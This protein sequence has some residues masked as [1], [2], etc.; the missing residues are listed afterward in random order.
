MLG[1]DLSSL[2]AYSSYQNLVISLYN[3]MAMILVSNHPHTYIYINK[4][5][6]Q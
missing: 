1:I 3:N 5:K 2:E 6:Q 4:T